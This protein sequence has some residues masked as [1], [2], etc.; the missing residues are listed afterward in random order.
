LAEGR[1]CALDA[2]PW[3]ALVRPGPRA[4]EAA[5]A[6]VHCLAALPPPRL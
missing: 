5:E 2:E 6:L 3:N 1:L 4:A